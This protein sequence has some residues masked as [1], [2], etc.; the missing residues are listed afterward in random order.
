MTNLILGYGRLG[1]ELV[2]QTNWHYITRS[3]DGFDF[4]NIKSYSYLLDDY[5]TIINCIAN[6]NTYS[7]EREDHLNVNFKAVCDLV[8]YCNLTNKKLIQISSDYVYANSV[9]NAS[10]EDIPVHARTWYTYSKILSDGYITVRSKNYLIA[11]CSFKTNPW[12]YVKASARMGNFDYTE[13]IA[14]LIIKLINKN[15]SG[16]YNVGTGVK[17][18]YDLAKQTNPNVILDTNIPESM[19]Q[20]VTMNLSK[21]ERFLNE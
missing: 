5:Q 13:T 12:P 20:S 10:E 2:A 7:N 1:K 16:I 14:R 11:R 19:P 3:I 17:S 15:A 4:C 9:E 18:L 6:T 8:D 21:M